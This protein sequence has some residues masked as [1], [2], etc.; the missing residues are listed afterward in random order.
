MQHRHLIEREV[1]RSGIEGEVVPLAAA[2][3]PAAARLAVVAAHLGV[4]V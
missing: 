4:D 3:S 1:A 2:T